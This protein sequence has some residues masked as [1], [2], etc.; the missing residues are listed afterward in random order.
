[1]E[2]SAMSSFI[3]APY[4]RYLLQTLHI[5]GYLK[6]HHSAR[7]VFQPSYRDINH[8]QFPKKYWSGFYSIENKYCRWM[9]L[10][11]EEMNL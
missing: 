6:C 1:M 8:E 9:H 7:L 3:A 5:F 4:Y 11:I 10:I 2:V